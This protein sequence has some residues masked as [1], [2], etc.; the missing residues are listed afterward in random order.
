SADGSTVAAGATFATV[1]GIV[2][3]GAVYVF[4]EPASGWTSGTQ[5]AKLTESDGGLDDH[6]GSSVAMSPD[7]ATVVARTG[8][9]DVSS[10]A[11]YIFKEPAS[12]WANGTETAEFGPAAHCVVDT[13][14]SPPVSLS[15]DGAVIVVGGGIA[16]L[17][18]DS[19]QGAV[20][21]FQTAQVNGACG[22]SNGSYFGTAHTS[23]L[24]S[25]GTASSITGSGPWTWSCTGLNGGT[26]ANCSAQF[27]PNAGLWGA[28][29]PGGGREWLS[30]FGYFDISSSRWI[31]HE[32]LGW[33]YPF[34]TSANS[35]WFWDR[36]MKTV[37][38]T[39]ATAYPFLYCPSQGTMLWYMK[40]TS[41]PGLFWNIRKGKWERY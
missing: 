4:E 18:T 33:L 12:G 27:S 9:G 31:Y 5:A 10:G 1:G 32:Q 3:E 41:N 7:G 13:N 14:L 30:W 20:F 21:V 37:L 24:C 36:N 16:P 28:S 11:V 25:S 35:I 22:S 19:T 2:R 40:G 8:Y 29:N 34:G 15:S 17:T 23:N 39:S 38:W 6:L 26:T